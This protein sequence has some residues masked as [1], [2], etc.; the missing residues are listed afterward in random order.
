MIRKL[1]FMIA[2]AAAVMLSACRPSANEKDNKQSELIVHAAASLTDVFKSLAPEFEK[3]N[4]S[5]KITYQFAGTQSLLNQIQSGAPGDVFASA[6][7]SYASV[8]VKSDFIIS[9]P[10]VFATNRLVIG[11]PSGNP[12]KILKLADLGRPNAVVALCAP[13]VPA[14]KYAR[15]VF[16]KAGVDVKP[17]TLEPHVRG[18]YNKISRGEVDAGIIYMSDL[19]TVRGEVDGIEIPSEVNVVARYPIAVLKSTKNREAADAFVQFIFSEAAAKRLQ[20]FGFA[21]P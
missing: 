17:S 1:I 4:A 21:K 8:L 18:V 19:K 16:K 2:T 13:E 6:D 11:V 15:E 9:E 14:G 10:K 20:M 7:E 3:A 12:K 5:V